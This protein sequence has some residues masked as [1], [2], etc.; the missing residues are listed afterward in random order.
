[1]KKLYF[2]F[3]LSI[4]LFSCNMN[5]TPN[6]VNKTQ[7][8]FVDLE[9]AVEGMTCEGCENT[10]ETELLKLEGVGEVNASHVNKIVKVKVDT[11]VNKLDDL[12]NNIERVGYT[13]IK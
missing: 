1:M 9:I 12:E 4:A 8:N 13:V 6:D 10:V 11:T 2:I 5:Q 3:I 7:L